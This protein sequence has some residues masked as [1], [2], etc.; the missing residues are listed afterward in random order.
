MKKKLKS[1]CLPLSSYSQATPFLSLINMEA[2]LLLA[3]LQVSCRE[4]SRTPHRQVWRPTG[5]QEKMNQSSRHF[6]FLC[7]FVHFVSQ[8]PRREQGWLSPWD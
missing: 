6:A 3:H 1:K 8:S 4:P 2:S 7:V 5:S